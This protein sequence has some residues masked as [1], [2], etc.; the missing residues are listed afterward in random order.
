MKK[1]V[2][3]TKETKG[4][5]TIYKNIADVQG[6]QTLYRVV[7][8]IPNGVPR[9]VLFPFGTRENLQ[10]WTSNADVN[11]AEIVGYICTFD[12]PNEINQIRIDMSVQTTITNKAIYLIGFGGSDANKRYTCPAVDITTEKKIKF[13]FSSN[14]STWSTSQTNAPVTINNNEKTLLGFELVINDNGKVVK[15]IYKNGVLE[16]TL[17]TNDTAIA[18]PYNNGMSLFYR[19]SGST[20]NWY[21]NNLSTDLTQLKIT[22]NNEVKVDG[23]L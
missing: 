6:L 22:V 14:G 10:I 4:T 19:V 2:D 7:N 17:V 16:W 11:S 18:K 8:T 3:L 15:N 21:I 20:G 1:F 9:Q 13:N 12:F 5:S 23:R